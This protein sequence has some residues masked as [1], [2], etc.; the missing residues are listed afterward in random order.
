MKS[1][2]GRTLSV[3]TENRDRC[4]KL[5]RL[6]RV[7]RIQAKGIRQISPVTSGEGVPAIVF[8]IEVLLQVSVT[9]EAGLFNKNIAGCKSETIRT[10][11]DACPVPVSERPFQRVQGPVNG[12]GN[13]NLLKQ[14]QCLAV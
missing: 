1:L 8:L 7:G 2:T 9:R 10:T 12:G 5:K 14:A 11:G 3:R 4:L 13:C 6:R